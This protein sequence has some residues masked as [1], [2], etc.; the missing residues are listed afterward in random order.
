MSSAGSG[1][2][3]RSAED[4][5]MNVSEQLRQFDGKHIEPLEA[6]ASQLVTREGSVD[7]LLAL[8]DSD[9]AKIQT[10]STWIL[11]WL[12]ERHVPLSRSQTQQVL[13]MLRDVTQW[14]AKLHLLQMLAGLKIPS[15]NVDSLHRFLR[16][17]LFD[18]NKLVRAWSYNGLFVLGDQH[19]RF[20][21]EVGELLK[22]AQHDPAAS[23][24]ARVRQ[25]C[26]TSSW[27]NHCG[28]MR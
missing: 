23:V 6:V 7:E 4:C 17:Q 16:E 22:K 18:D 5:D 25:I 15:R 14:E 11:K 28:T 13:R 8:S 9:D 3:D 19:G 1:D 24:R 26:K 2:R 20:R 21:T 27:A 12:H 10:A